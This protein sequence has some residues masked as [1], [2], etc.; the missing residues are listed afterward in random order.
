MCP[1][2]GSW[3]DTVQCS[4]APCVVLPQV[5]PRAPLF[6]SA[7]WNSAHWRETLPVP[8]VT[9]HSCPVPCVLWAHAGH[10]ANLGPPSWIHSG[11]K[12]SAC[13][14]SPFPPLWAEFAD[15]QFLGPSCSTTVKQV[16][17]CTGT[18]V[19]LGLLELLHA[20]NGCRRGAVWVAV[21][22]QWGKCC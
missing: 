12:C 22:S 6:A 9:G 5:R 1:C 13:L 15:L 17:L 4:Q 18:V 11:C 19:S 3:V 20:S 7:V 14:F 10:R 2:Q 16:G 8:K 21:H